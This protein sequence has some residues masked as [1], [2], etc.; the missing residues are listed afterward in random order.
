MYDPTPEH[1]AALDPTTSERAFTLVYAARLA[2]VPLI[3][4]SSRRSVAEQA[5]L[6]DAGRSRTLQS[7]HITGRA[8]D[9]DVFGFQRDDVPRN[10]IKSRDSH[11]CCSHISGPPLALRTSS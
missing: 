9:V 7:L 11:A 5:A 6:V 3:I 8:F 2:G 1:L 4:T 10:D